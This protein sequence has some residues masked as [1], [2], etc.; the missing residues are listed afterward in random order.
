MLNLEMGDGVFDDG[1]RAE[2]GWVEDVADVSVHEDI[3]RFQ[4]EEGGFGAASVGAANPENLRGLA[5]CHCWEQTGV[6]LGG[7]DG[8]FFVVG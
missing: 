2:V 6:F 8:P 4:A 1:G 5:R 3:T 7:F